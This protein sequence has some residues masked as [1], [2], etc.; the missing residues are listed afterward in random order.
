MNQLVKKNASHFFQ[1]HPV[2]DRNPKEFIQ[3][4][5]PII[6]VVAVE[7]HTRDSH[8]HILEIPL[9]LLEGHPNNASSA[10]EIAFI[11]F[12]DH[13]GQKRF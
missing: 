12:L 3:V 4:Y 10:V 5:H 1:K 7:S 8:Q 2:I 9:E 13:L 11:K 6:P